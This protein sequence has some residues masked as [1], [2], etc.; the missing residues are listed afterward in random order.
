MTEQVSNGHKSNLR[1]DIDKIADG[2]AEILAGLARQDAVLLDHGRA[3]NG[4]REDLADERRQ[5]ATLAE[6]LSA[7]LDGEANR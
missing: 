2:Q 5:R 4:V 3:L 7:H 6:R 1:E